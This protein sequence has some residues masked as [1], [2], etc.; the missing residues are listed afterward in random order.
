VAKT[1]SSQQNLS[2]CSLVPTLR[3]MRD[4]AST[5]RT[6]VVPPQPVDPEGGHT[7]DVGP[8]PRADTYADTDFP[9][10]TEF[11]SHELDQECLREHICLPP[12]ALQ[13]AWGSCR[14]EELGRCQHLGAGP[15]SAVG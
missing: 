13:P 15:P 3:L 8:P 2:P 12:D 9:T 11:L 7:R 1:G 10:L 5:V 6:G 4:F 14:L